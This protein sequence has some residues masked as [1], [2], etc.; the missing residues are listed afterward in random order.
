MF[1]KLFPLGLTGDPL[2]DRELPGV[3]NKPNVRKSQ[4]V[5]SL[6]EF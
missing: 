4:N 2:G 1:T 3:V 5:L 6:G